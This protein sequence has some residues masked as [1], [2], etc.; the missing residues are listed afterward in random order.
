MTL[1][2]QI[3]YAAPDLLDLESSC[4]FTMRGFAVEVN[5]NLV[6]RCKRRAAVHVHVEYALYVPQRFFRAGKRC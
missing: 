3:V 6:P 5:A 1:H 2:L 4:H